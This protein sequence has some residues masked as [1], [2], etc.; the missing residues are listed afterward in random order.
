MGFGCLTWI[1]GVVIRLVLL[2]PPGA[3]KGTQSGWL[4]GVTGAVHISTGDLVRAAI[5]DGTPLGRAVQ[6]YHD[7]GE[8]VPDQ[9]I[10]DLVRPYLAD[11]RGWILDGFPRDVA[12]AAALDEALAALGLPLQR[13]IALQVDDAALAQRLEARRLSA[14]T[15]AIYNLLYEPPP[16]ED[17][18]PFVQRADDHPEEIRRR[19]QVYHE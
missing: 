4:A 12:Q 19:L 2:G 6:G 17:P 15:G 3:G 16:P 5:A 8:L 10:V 13:V 7:R 14:A 1:G 9:V 11:P 18:G